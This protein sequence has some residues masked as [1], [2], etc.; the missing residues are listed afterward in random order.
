M[1]GHRRPKRGDAP[2]NMCFECVQW[3]DGELDFGFC[4]WRNKHGDEI[5]RDRK[6]AYSR[7]CGMGWKESECK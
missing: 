4:V 1:S 6:Y 2:E 3:E 5:I 7:M